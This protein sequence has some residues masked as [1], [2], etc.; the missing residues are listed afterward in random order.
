[1]LP[2]SL[3]SVFVLAGSEAATSGPSPAVQASATDVRYGRDV[4]PI[5]SDRCFLCHGTEP[6]QRQADLRLDLEELATAERDGG[7]AI[8]PGDSAAS[9]LWRRISSDDPD[10]MM[11][12]PGSN[13]RALTAEQKETL[14]DWIDEGAKYQDHWAF[15]PPE[16]PPVPDAAPHPIDAYVLEALAKQGLEASP[17]LEPELAL[18]RLFLDLT[19]LPPTPDEL[20]AY[21][22]E[23]AG[24]DADA[25]WASWVDRLFTEEPY[26]SRYAERMASPW[27]DQARYADTNGIHMDAGRQMWLWRDW[28]LA[29]YRDNKPFDEFVLEQIAGDQLPEATV[30]QRV[31]S[32]F[33]RNHVITDEGGAISAEYL[34][35]YAVDRADTTA[36]VFLGLTMGCARCHDHKFDPITQED[37]YRLFDFF[38]SNDEPGLYTQQPNPRRAFEPALEVPTDEQRAMQASLRTEREELDASLASPSSEELAALDAFLA[39]LPERFGLHHAQAEL[40]S[41][42]AE[43]DAVLTLLE[44]G[45]ALASGANPA[46]DAFELVLRTEATDLRVLQLDVLGHESLPEGRPGRAPNGNAVLSGLE[47]EV[48][49]VQD[50]EQRRTLGFDWLWASHEQANGPFNLEG[51]LDA[52]PKS[53]WAIEGHGPVGDRVALFGTHEAFGYEGGTEVRIRLAFESVYTQHTFGRVRIGLAGLAE[54]ALDELPLKQGRW[55]HVGPFEVSAAEAYGASFGP[56]EVAE[57]DPSRTFQDG[58]SERRWTFQETYRDETLV[59]LTGGTNVHYVAKEFWSPTERELEVAIGSDDGF[60]LYVNGTEVAAREVPRGVAPDQDRATLPLRS[61]R[62]LLVF[63]IVNTGGAAGFWFKALPGTERLGADVLAAFADG[64]ALRDGGASLRESVTHAWRLTRSPEYS[65]GLARLASIDEELAAI[66]AAIPRTM[67]MRDRAEPRQTYVLERGEYDKPNEERPVNGDIPGVFG[68]LGGQGEGSRLELA[69]WMTSPDNPLVAR[70]AVNRLWQL[71][72]GRG[73]VPTSGNFGYQGAWPSHPALLDWL[74]VEFVESGWDVQHVLR[75]VVTSDTYRQSAHATEAH[76]AADPDNVWLARFPRRRLDAERLRDQALYVSGLLVEE[77]GGE[78]VKP[79]QPDGL[80]REVAMLQSNTRTFERGMG[81][82]LWRRSVYTYWKRACPPP[83]MLT[84]DA[85]TRE[86]CVVERPMTNTPLQALVLW[87]DEQFLEAARVLA[88]RTLREGTDDA[89]RL[90]L[91]FRRCTGRAPSAAESTALAETLA[92]LRTRY[93]DGGDDAAALASVGESM[94][95][96]DL[97]PSEVAA[98]TLVAN[99]LLNLHATITT[100]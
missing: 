28:V 26:R 9:E 21:L 78:S 35:E 13:R 14:R 58:E 8:V 60:A 30:A 29:A 23:L 25:V 37:Y 92:A 61:G 72:F 83:S 51:I 80:W 48:L 76:L 79:Y 75:T 65:A 77:F 85:P 10:F 33:N 16:R 27:L 32:G 34:V 5:L 53:G 19:G 44:D 46:T 98:W 43:S 66:Q 36:Q 6:G 1:M 59:N 70:V 18:R 17:A 91:M 54:T 69:R 39:E 100:G 74:A 97:D 56:E 62:N 81:T 71:V 68:G 87:N 52:D 84:F 22:D 50:P 90:T 94:A 55:H 89:E 93:A 41:A 88:E 73:L 67:V 24:G 7:A 96:D 42:E 64:D 99:A 40:V 82:D 57:L 20:D 38:Y 49:S 95:A 15:T 31:A 3:L 47:V 63:K 11:P 12:P 45:S 4:R 86:S 2:L